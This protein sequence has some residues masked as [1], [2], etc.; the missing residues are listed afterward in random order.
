MVWSP[1][2][3]PCLLASR[4]PAPR[5]RRPSG[6]A[7]TFDAIAGAVGLAEGVAAGDQ[8]DGLLV[9]HR[10]AGEGL[11]DVARRCERVGLAVR[12]LPD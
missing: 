1:M 6:S 2:P 10:H 7:P 3:V 4:G 5:C 8:R 11:A 12:A 9:V